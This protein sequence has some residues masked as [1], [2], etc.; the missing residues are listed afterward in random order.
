LFKELGL[1]DL[2]GIA[3]MDGFK[4]ELKEANQR[5]N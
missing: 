4:A 1:G 2:A 3:Q 5:N